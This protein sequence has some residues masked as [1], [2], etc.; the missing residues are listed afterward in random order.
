MVRIPKRIKSRRRTFFG[1]SVSLG[2]K[3]FPSFDGA[4]PFAKR[5]CFFAEHVG[6]GS[7]TNKNL[8]RIFGTEARIHSVRRRRARGSDRKPACLRQTFGDAQKTRGGGG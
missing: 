7:L 8:H 1:S 3:R 2:E 4:H 5:I 6:H